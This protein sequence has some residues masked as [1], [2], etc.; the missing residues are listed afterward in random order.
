MSFENVS[1]SQCARTEL[2]RLFASYVKSEVSADECRMIE[3]HLS[4]CQECQNR[5]RAILEA[6][7][8]SLRLQ[9]PLVDSK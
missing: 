3:E 9:S 6:Q 1:A 2:R 4:E 8:P 5:L 7:Q